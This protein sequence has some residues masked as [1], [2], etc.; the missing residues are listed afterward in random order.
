MSISH[1]WNEKW[2]CY[3]RWRFLNC[4]FITRFGSRS[5]FRFKPILSAP[6]T[7][8]SPAEFWNGPKIETIISSGLRLL[9]CHPLTYTKDTYRPLIDHTNL[10]NWW[11]S[12]K[13]SN[14]DNFKSKFESNLN[15]YNGIQK[16]GQIEWDRKIGFGKCERKSVRKKTFST[17]IFAVDRSKRISW[18]NFVKMEQPMRLENAFK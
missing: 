16:M 7:I 5:D 11:N 17:F 6:P 3:N 15:K 2:W 12:T 18:F 8:C 10:L 4:D 9:N 13:G 14:I 1:A